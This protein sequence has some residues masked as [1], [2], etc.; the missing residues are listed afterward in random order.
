MLTSFTLSAEIR[1]SHRRTS[2]LGVAKW[3]GRSKWLGERSGARRLQRAKLV[4]TTLHESDIQ[5]SIS[6]FSSDSIDSIN[7]L[8]NRQN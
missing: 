1:K 3:L 6:E 5:A 8:I 7:Y 4:I 2:L